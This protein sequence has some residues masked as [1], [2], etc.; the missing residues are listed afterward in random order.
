MC[1]T[2]MPSLFCRDS[3]ADN[4]AEFYKEGDGRMGGKQ[5]LQKSWRDSGKVA[6]SP[7]LLS[8]S[9]IH[10]SPLLSMLPLTF[11]YQ[12]P[13][14]YGSYKANY[15]HSNAR[16]SWYLLSFCLHKESKRLI[17]LWPLS[18]LTELTSVCLPS[19]PHIPG[20]L[21]NYLLC[22]SHYFPLNCVAPQ[23]PLLS[24][25][26]FVKRAPSED[27]LAQRKTC[28]SSCRA[29]LTCLNVKYLKYFQSKLHH[30][31]GNGKNAFSSN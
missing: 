27:R 25:C 28:P 5:C 23:N 10:T 6:F 7:H 1:S 21:F 22:Y 20:Y 24:P 26:C 19:L 3:I 9:L 15:L 8:Y 17:L 14:L 30:P 12:L 2:A 18:K 29:G 11:L 31:W 13:I 16:F 4:C